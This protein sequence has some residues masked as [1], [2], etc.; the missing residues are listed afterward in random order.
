MNKSSEFSFMLKPSSIGGVGVFAT[1]DLSEGAEVFTGT[2]SPKKMK[3]EDV[4]G[5][6]RQYCIYINDEECLCPEK[7]DRM[8][9]DWFVNHSNTPNVAKTPEG[10]VFTLRKIKAGEE[11]VC[12]YNLLNEPDHLKEEYYRPSKR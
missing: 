9:I 7:F 3:L 11:I 4:P 8:E 12:D 10:K 6:L 1:H 2:F 5:P